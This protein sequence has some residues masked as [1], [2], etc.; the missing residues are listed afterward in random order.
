MRRGNLF[1]DLMLLPLLL[2]L[3]KLESCD[4]F[5]IRI[6]GY[7]ELE[8]TV[9][10]RKIR[11]IT[12]ACFKTHYYYSRLFGSKSRNNSRI[13]SKYRDWLNEIEV[14][15]LPTCAAAGT[16]DTQRPAEEAS[17]STQHQH[18]TSR[19]VARDQI[20]WKNPRPSS[21]R[22]CRPIRFQFAKE[23]KE[24]SVQ[25]ETYF[26]NEM[27]SLQPS[28][29]THN[30]CEI[31]VLHS[32][33]STMVDAEITGLEKDLIERCHNLLQCLSSGYKINNVAFKEYALDPA[34]KLVAAYPWYNLPSS[35]HKVL[36]HGSK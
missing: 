1:M 33:Q 17:T 5:I 31:K 36:I 9:R 20:V 3:S 16:H 4:G 32:L 2:S 24:L 19:I 35:V 30:G 27:N 28:P 11:E 18:R 13:V 21:T 7:M 14:C 23:S 25:E 29:F 15:V 8:E 12:E 34:R 10:L 22:Y 26:K 6:T